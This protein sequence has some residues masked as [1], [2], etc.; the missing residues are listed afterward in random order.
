[1][2]L[3]KKQEEKEEEEEEEE[4]EEPLEYHKE[5]VAA[6]PCQE[7]P[8]TAYQ[9]VHVQG[10][11]IRHAKHALPVRPTSLCRLTPTANSLTLPLTI[12]LHTHFPG[13]S[14]K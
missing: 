13:A 12:T 9:I 4:E 11:H 7:E 5:P 1:M 3:G 6:W 10:H 8:D 2:A 14:A